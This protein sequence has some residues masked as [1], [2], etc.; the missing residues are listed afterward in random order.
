MIDLSLSDYIGIA[1]SILSLVATV[2]VAFIQCR[3]GKKM[4]DFEKRQDER[5]EKRHAESVESQAV[6]FISKYNKD[7]GP[8]PLCAVATMYDKFFHY[9]REMYREFCCMTLEVQN[10]ILECCELD[11]SIQAR[12]KRD[13]DSFFDRCFKALNVYCTKTFPAHAPTPFYDNGKYIKGCLVHHGSKKIP[14]KEIKYRPAYAD[15]PMA[16]AFFINK[17]MC[18]YSECITDTLRDY[19]EGNGPEKPIEFLEQK[20]NFKIGPEIEACQFA[21]TLAYYIAVSGDDEDDSGKNYEAPGHYNGEL[22]DTME[23][24]FLQTLFGIYIHLVLSKKE[25]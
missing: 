1:T 25:C 5:D 6:S 22:I 15:N 9:S 14:V 19:F 23:D 11:L 18:T 4:A 12:E 13:N 8:I 7:R 16:S 10:K 2:I 3:Q 24:L 21:A 17:E 20:Y